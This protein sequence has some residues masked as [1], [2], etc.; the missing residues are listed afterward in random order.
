M[1]C[2]TSGSICS[3]SKHFAHK[4]NRAPNYSLVILRGIESTQSHIAQWRHIHW[5]QS[6]A[7]ASSLELTSFLG[8]FSFP[9][10]PFLKTLRSSY[11]ASP[12]K[13]SL[14]YE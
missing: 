9:L 8:S 13:M 7:M 5:R 14:T 3:H 6:F 11:P 4:I 10:G 2:V 12:P 1:V